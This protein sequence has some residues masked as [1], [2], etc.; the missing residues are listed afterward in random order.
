MLSQY[1]NGPALAKKKLLG[2][3][4]YFI[5]E[6][7]LAKTFLDGAAIR[8]PNGS[9]IIALTV[10]YDRLDNFWFVLFH[11]L[12]HIY[13]HFGTNEDT[14]FFD[15]VNVDS[16]DIESEADEFALKTLL[17]KDS[18]ENCLSRYSLDVDTVREEAQQLHVHSAI[19]A[20]RIRYEQNNYTILNDAIGHTEVSKNFQIDE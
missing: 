5:I 8:H 3:G 9:P 12:A 1:E 20:G 13:L 7:H 17:P 6:R 11:E 10:R 18:W 4:I 16:N 19:I 15:D 2:S 14:D